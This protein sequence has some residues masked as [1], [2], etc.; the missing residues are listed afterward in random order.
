M[1]AVLE[2]WVCS[3]LEG[4]LGKE[5]VGGVLVEGHLRLYGPVLVV[6][7]GLCVVVIVGLYV[8]GFS[9]GLLLSLSVTSAMYTMLGVRHLLPRGHVF[10]VQLHNRVGVADV[11]RISC[12]L[13]PLM[14]CSRFGMQL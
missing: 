6:V 9:F 1:V 5:V 8:V 10:L 11:D 3:L 4:V 7:V 14:I 12:E 2:M 13:W